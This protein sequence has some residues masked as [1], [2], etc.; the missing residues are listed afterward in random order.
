MRVF[1]LA[2]SLGVTAAAV[3][4]FAGPAEAATCP[5]VDPST[6]AVTPAP[7]PGVQWAGCDL[8]GAD[9]AGANM[10]Q[11]N[12]NGAELANA[13]LTGATLKGLD[14]GSADLTNAN[15]TDAQLMQAI[16]SDATFTGATL[17]GVSSGGISG[18]PAALPSDWLLVNNYLVGPG[19]SLRNAGLGDADL[20]NVDL[21]GADLTDASLR[22]TTLTGADLAGATLTGLASSGITGTPA[23]LPD[24][25]SVVGG[26]LVGPAADLDSADLINLDLSGLTLTGI[27]LNAADLSGASLSGTNLNDAI[28]TAVNLGGADLTGA[29]LAGE[30][31]G[32]VTGTPAALPTG[33]SITGGFLIGPGADL[34][35][36]SLVGLKLNGSDLSGADL[37]D[38]DLVNAS[39]DSANLTSADLSGADVENANLTSAALDQADLDGSNVQGSNLTD[40]KLAGANLTNALLADSTLTGASLAGATLTGASGLSIKGTPASL[41]A[42]WS[43]VGG[44]LIGPGAG[45]YLTDADLNSRDL[46]GVDFSGLTLLRTT[47]EHANLTRANLTKA[48]LTGADFTSANLTKADLDGATVSSTNFTGTVWSDTICPDGSNSNTLAHGRCFAPPPASPFTAHSL[49]TP[50]GDSVN[51]FIPLAISCPTA[52]QCSAGASYFDSQSASNLAALLHWTGKLWSETKAPLPSDAAK[53]LREPSSLTSMSCPSAARCLA[54]GNYQSTAGSDAMLLS[55]SG[56]NWTAAQAPLPA[57]ANQNPVAQVTGMACP[58]TTTCF[59]VGAYSGNNN[60]Y[61]LLL[62]WSGGKWT[63]ATAPTPAGSPAIFLSAVS[64]P[65]TTLCFAAGDSGSGALILRWSAG[66]W[67]VVKVPLPSGAATIPQVDMG[68]L[69]C[70]TTTHC[71]AVGSY[72]DTQGREQGLLLTRSGT[73]WTAA[74]APVL[75]GAASNP[76]VSLDSVSCPTASQCTVGGGYETTA[77]QPVGLLLLWSGKTWKAAPTPSGA[78]MVKG[79]SC[80]TTTRCVAVSPDVAGPV[81]LTGP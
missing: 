78:Y 73:T 64:C 72:A 80:P 71:V 61:G 62:H 10:T 6:G 69:S 28:L 75:A 53:G 44:Y 58:S 20:T 2:A 29:S 17:T 38:T 16:L 52:T 8:T 11:G 18:T 42:H 27:N 7:G 77:A 70:P 51:D 48:N 81:A 5:T 43:V 19:A 35:G 24:N 50:P 63:A 37:S 56:K 55:W 15:L 60:E 1:R 31:S 65:S 41:P 34:H 33:W 54:G 36:A 3:I 59:A 25:W 47:F 49:P 68:G 45:T 76:S 57:N 79:I 32:E 22:D 21:S 12:L 23:S 26:Y 39:L 66:K 14:L 40:A 4:L 74:K 9:L 67:A 46:T 13:N 30:Q